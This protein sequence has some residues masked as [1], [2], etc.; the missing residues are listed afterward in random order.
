[1][2][3]ICF[4]GASYAYSVSGGITDP[5]GENLIDSARSGGMVSPESGQSSTTESKDD[6]MAKFVLVGA[7]FGST[8]G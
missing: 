6:E 7:D 5:I 3:Y 1:M 2:M 8:Q 4:G